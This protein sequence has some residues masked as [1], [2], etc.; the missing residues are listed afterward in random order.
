MVEQKEGG[1]V[2]QKET[3]KK[4]EMKGVREEERVVTDRW[5]V[6][7]YIHRLYLSDKGKEEET[8]AE[9]VEKRRR[10]RGG[11]EEWTCRRGREMQRMTE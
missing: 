10:L 2:G 7:S 3:E 4:G 11:G 5:V 1:M 6:L 9:Y 8:E